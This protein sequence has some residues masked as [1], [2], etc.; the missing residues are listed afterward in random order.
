MNRREHHVRAALS[1]FDSLVRRL[2][3]QVFALSNA[4]IMVIFKDVALDEIQAALIKL[5]FL[6]DDDPLLMHERDPVPGPAQPPFVEWFVVDKDYAALLQLAQSLV[7]AD[8]ERRTHE[9]RVSEAEAPPPQRQK[10]RAPLTPLLLAKMQ[11]ALAG[12]DLANML[13]RQAVCALVGQAPPQPLFY[14]LFVSITELQETLLPGVDLGSSPWLFQLLTE[15][16]DHRVLSLLNRHDDSTLSGDVSINLNVQ[17][18]LSPDFLEFDDGIK[19]SQRGTIVLELQKVDI[20]ADLS[21]FLFARDFA[22]ERGYRICI[23][24][25]TVDSLPLIDRGRLGIDLLKLA[26]DASLVEGQLSDG[27]GLADYVRRCGP[28]RTILCR[29]DTAHAISLGQAVGI[30]LFQGRHVE[31]LLAAEQH[32]LRGGVGRRRP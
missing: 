7:N 2:K 21:A 13:R 4:D 8:M 16:L 24:G 1:T 32:R 15:T 26:W 27:S 17:T 30:T 12:A 11:Q 29:C 28:S 31:Q 19:A 25:V 20:F 18:L 10:R 9:Q 14:E 5:R 6:F 22:R 23:D 3:G